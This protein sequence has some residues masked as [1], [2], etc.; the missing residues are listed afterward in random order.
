MEE[1]QLYK[2]MSDYPSG[3][4]PWYLFWVNDNLDL[5]DLHFVLRC[6]VFHLIGSFFIVV[7]KHTEI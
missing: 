2:L 1:F 7:S 3:N 5:N 4:Q 6:S